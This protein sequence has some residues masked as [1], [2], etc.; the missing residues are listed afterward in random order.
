[1]ARRPG[2]LSDTPFRTVFGG[3]SSA[4]VRAVLAA[5]EDDYHGVLAEVER[6]RGQFDDVTAQLM[7]VH[8][9]ERE[10][11]LVISRAE[12]DAQAI[13]RR[14]QDRADA[15]EREAENRLAALMRQAEA[16]REALDSQIARCAGN[17]ARL[18]GL[19]QTEIDL[20]QALG[21]DMAGAEPRAGLH[22]QPIPEPA[23]IEVCVEP[24]G[25]EIAGG[26]S[27][28]DA[29]DAITADATTGDASPGDEF[30]G[31]ESTG[32]EA[33]AR[34][35]TELLSPA[36]NGPA[37]AWSSEDI[38][39]ALRALTGSTT[40]PT[41]APEAPAPRPDRT[42]DTGE[43]TTAPEITSIAADPRYVAAV[44]AYLKEA[45]PEHEVPA[46][47]VPRS[48]V[49]A[50][51]AAA[52]GI[53]V[54]LAFPLFPRGGATSSQPKA[55]HPAAANAPATAPASSTPAKLATPLPAAPAP[56][57][58]K[59]SAPAAAT[60][61]LVIRVQASRPCWIGLTADGRKESRLLG[62]G[63]EIVRESDSDIVLRAGDAGAL[64]VTVNG[65][66][67]SPLGDEGEVVTRRFSAPPR[68]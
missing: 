27:T 36:E 56:P 24:A 21:S 33:A 44:N 43:G 8:A 45:E 50:A 31:A 53:I 12:T 3:V 5:V 52:L 42:D 25:D 13:R 38:E 51:G 54:F 39:S 29:S 30:P 58:A 34:E 40:Q 28:G 35:I 19:L 66:R 10:T 49:M 2:Q 65:R 59:P 14:A 48:A 7:A 4:E 47:S 62:Q 16:E 17:R 26:E 6:L 61:A 67:L 18:A 32:Y 11:T 64:M 1:M 46:K 41:A 9:G 68:N 55:G 60:R 37:E 23:P 63:E 15:I 20:L 22:P 57:P